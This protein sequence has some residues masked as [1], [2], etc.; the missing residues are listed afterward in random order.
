MFVQYLMDEI[1]GCGLAVR[2]GHSDDEEIPGRIA[3]HGIGDLSHEPFPPLIEETVL[4]QEVDLIV[5]GD[6]FDERFEHDM[7]SRKVNAY[8]R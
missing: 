5:E 1:H 2:A 8:C 6:L 4:E 7:L 3:V